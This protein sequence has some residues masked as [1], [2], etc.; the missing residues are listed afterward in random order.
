[1][2]AALVDTKRVES[3][4]KELLIALGEDPDRR[5]L[6]DTPR[7]VAKMYSELLEGRGRSLED[8]IDVFFEARYD[9]LIVLKGIP[10]YSI[11]EHHLLP[12][13]GH[14]HVGYI[15][16]KQGQITGLSKLARLVETASRRLQLQERMT[17]EI[18]DAIEARLSPRG[19]IVVIQAD[20]LCMAM[21]GVKKV[22]TQ[23][24]TSAVRGSLRS[25]A[26]TRDE[27]I[28]LLIS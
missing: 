5:D 22:G 9:E 14:T 15:P 26:A 17:I 12:W 20:H 19:V 27:A 25:S 2:G 11:C 4:I 10:T 1:M 6:L 21:R 18:A 23:T 7:R 16:N 8:E 3:L 13:H 28:R 24:L